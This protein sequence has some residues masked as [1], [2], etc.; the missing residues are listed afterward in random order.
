MKKFPL[1]CPGCDNR[2]KV[3]SLECENCG[4]LVT[5]SYPLPLLASL[6]KEEQ[7][8]VVAFVKESGR[9]NVMARQLH[10]SYPTVRNKLDDLINKIKRIELENLPPDKS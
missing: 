1:Y 8:F 2:L 4:T 6:S 5:G 3:K 7:E 10:L 9:L